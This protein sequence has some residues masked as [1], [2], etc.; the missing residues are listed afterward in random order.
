MRKK[1]LHNN[2]FS[3][4]FGDKTDPHPH[5]AFGLIQKNLQAK[6]LTVFTQAHGTQGHLVKQTQW[7][8]AM[9]PCRE[10][11]KRTGDILLTNHVGCALGILTADCLPIIFY[12]PDH[13]A[14]A[15]AHAGWRGAAA[16]VAQKTI[17]LMKEHFS[18]DPASLR[19]YFGPSARVCCYEVQPDFCDHIETG[20]HKAVFVRK[21]QKLLFDN[22]KLNY[23][24]LRH[25]G[26]QAKHI[27]CR[28]NTCT[29]CDRSYHSYRR[30]GKNYTHQ[31]TVVALKNPL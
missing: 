12:D 13:H 29:I 21:A 31:V 7:C 22:V 17:A 4:Y 24:Q 6:S 11:F 26:V 23:L 16:G 1:H 27:C 10:L 28:N 3:I 30:D 2:N 19:V 15:I 8:E 25:M 20:Y 14:C 18:S 9:P 5:E